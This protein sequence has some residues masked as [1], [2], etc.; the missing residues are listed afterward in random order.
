MNK[1]NCDATTPSD[2]KKTENSCDSVEVIANSY[3]CGDLDIRIDRNGLWF[4]HGSPIGRKNLVRLFASVLQRD[5]E[6]RFWL[7]TP[8]EKGEIQVEDA[9]FAAVEMMVDG[10]GPDQVISFRT[11]VDDIVIVDAKHRIRIT[12]DPDTGEPSPYVEVRD[13]LDA[14]LTR[15]VFYE[16]VETSLDQARDEERIL[17]VWSNGLSFPI[18]N[19]DEN[20]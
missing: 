2:L 4:Y 6:G 5:S 17:V 13:G 18:G 9:P 12:T 10:T 8:T 20:A 11:N 14:R 7:V 16:L 15:S 1:K 19:L 3:L